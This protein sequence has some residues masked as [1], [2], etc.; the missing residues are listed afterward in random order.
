MLNSL[1]VS[2]IMPAYNSEAILPDTIEAIINQSYSNWELIIVDDCSSDKTFNILESYSAIDKRIKCFRNLVNMGSPLTRNEALKHA[3]GRYIAF[4]DADDLF[5]PTKLEKQLSFMQSKK[6]SFTYTW[7]RRTS[8]DL[9]RTGH[10]IKAPHYMTYNRL[11]SNTAICTSTVMI[12]L[13]VVEDL[14][15]IDHHLHDF[16]LWLNILKTKE[17][18]AV[19]FPHDL[20]RYRVLDQSF[21]SNKKKQV[22]EMYKCFSEMLNLNMTKK[23]Y[24]MT[25]YAYHAIIKHVRF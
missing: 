11:L 7:Y 21:S 19:C 24:C 2:I 4:C 23:L 25:G 12:D 1:L 16:L 14:T 10:L 17:D 9:K 6:V 20:L 3:K 13:S 5:M 15:M 18:K 8:T 22:K